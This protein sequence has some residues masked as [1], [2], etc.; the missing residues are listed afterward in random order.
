MTLKQIISSIAG[1]ILALSVATGLYEVN[2]V[3]VAHATLSPRYFKPPQRASIKD[4][5]CLTQAIYYEAGN[6]SSVGKEAVALVVMNRVGKRG[7]PNTVCGVVRQFAVVEDRKICQF[8]FWCG[9]TPKPTQQVWIES[10]QIA[11]RVLHNYW[12][13]AILSRYDGALF[14]HADYV[15]PRWR[16]QKVFLGK[17]DNHLFYGE[18]SRGDERRYARR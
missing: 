10:E 9:R 17:I 11:Y 14:Y 5:H 18:H 16:K 3:D 2:S 15:H 8:S 1:V 6:Q 7:Y 12:N 4:Q 13:R